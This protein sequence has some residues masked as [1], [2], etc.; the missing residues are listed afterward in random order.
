[1]SKVM[2]TLDRNYGSKSIHSD[3]SS[4]APSFV[5]LT[6]NELAALMSIALCGLDCMGGDKPSD[7]HEDNMSWFNQTDIVRGAQVS[8]MAARGLM[9]FL[10]RKELIADY[11]KGRKGALPKNDDGTVKDHWTLTDGGI[12]AAQQAW[13]SLGELDPEVLARRPALARALELRK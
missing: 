5:G 10:N 9:T 1:M 6:E 13:N 12:N 3:D 2:I 11:E 7:L 8:S 4:V